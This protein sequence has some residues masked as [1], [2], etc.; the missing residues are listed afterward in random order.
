MASR[1]TTRSSARSSARKK[2]TATAT[3]TGSKGTSKR[4]GATRASAASSTTRRKSPGAGSG[5]RSK[6]RTKSDT[7]ARTSAARTT[8]KRSSTSASGAGPSKAGA[9]RG[10]AGPR[11]TKSERAAKTFSEAV[12][13]A[14][15]GFLFDA[16][17]LFRDAIETDPRGDLADDALFNVG[18]I[19]L[20]MGLLKDAEASFTEL[21]EQYP[22]ATISSTLGAQETGRT[23]AKAHLGR[24]RARLAAGNR[25]GARSDLMALAGFTDSWVTDANG[26]R[27]TFYDL[28]IEAFGAPPVTS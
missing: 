13:R 8:P 12:E 11:G 26:V 17:A 14:G 21:I 28:G 25:D 10:A 22:E 27:R 16:I 20:Q 7:T 5:T 23:A 6:A 1:K 2:K 18:G 4:T 15:Q 19:Y 3:R 9:K 24:L